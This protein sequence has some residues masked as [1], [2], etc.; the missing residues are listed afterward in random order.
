MTEWLSPLNV[1]WAGAVLLAAIASWWVRGA[2]APE[3]EPPPPETDTVTV[4]RQITRRDTVTETVPR[5]VIQYDTVR[6]TRRDTIKIE[7]PTVDT[8]IADTTAQVPWRPFGLIRRRPVR[9]EGTTF[10]LSYYAL[11]GQRWEQ[12]EYEA[13]V[14]RPE[15]RFIANGDLTA[16]AQYAFTSSTLGLAKRTSIGWLSVQAGYGLS[17]TDQ[18]RRGFVGRVTLRSTLYSW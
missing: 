17:V 8:V 16:G 15:W 10:T 6:A 2:V 5:K 14:S 1:L 18:V 11:S 13:D 4:E 7:V 12:R 9:V 3:P